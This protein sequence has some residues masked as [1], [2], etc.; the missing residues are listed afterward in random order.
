M[1]AASVQHTL[2]R[3]LPRVCCRQHLAFR[4]VTDLERVLRFGTEMRTTA[5]NC[6]KIVCSPDLNA[7]DGR[8]LQPRR[9]RLY[10]FDTS[11]FHSR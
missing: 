8:I 3:L 7:S 9:L 5:V 6:R 11:I 4:N 2:P 1:I 10:R